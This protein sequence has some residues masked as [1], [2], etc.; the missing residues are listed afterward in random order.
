MVNGKT[1]GISGLALLF[2]IIFSSPFLL[3]IALVI[4]IVSLCQNNTNESY[5][6]CNKCKAEVSEKD[7][8]CP[9]CGSSF[10]NYIKCKKCKTSNC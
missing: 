3:V 7:E 10:G 4:F 9:E 1:M 5:F 6:V 8:F 2:G